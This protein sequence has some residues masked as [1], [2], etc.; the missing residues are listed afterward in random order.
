MRFQEL[1]VVRHAHALERE[2]WNEL[3]KPD[4]LRPLT[5]KGIERFGES[6]AAFQ[7]F[8]PKVDIIFC[9]HYTR[10]V[11][12]AELLCKIWPEAKLEVVEALNPGHGTK[13]MRR[14]IRELDDGAVAVIVGHQPELSDLSAALL[15][16]PSSMRLRYKKGGAALISMHD[17]SAQLQWLLS[18]RQLGM[19]AK[20]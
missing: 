13:G 1:L 18:S 17:E 6:L 15:G 2:K 12:T 16:A 8:V 7:K 5:K 14:L 20:T 11:Q 9:S 19:L 3:G 4:A 10:A